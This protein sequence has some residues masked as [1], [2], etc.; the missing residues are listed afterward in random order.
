[1][2][3]AFI[4]GEGICQFGHAVSH[5][6]LTV[7]VTPPPP[8]HEGGAGLNATRLGGEV[9][10]KHW[11]ADYAHYSVFITNPTHF[12]RALVSR[13]HKDVPGA[14]VR[15]TGPWKCLGISIPRLNFL[16]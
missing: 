16:P 6:G 14:K 9:N 3:G 1:M 12:T 2:Y 4:Y 8:R 10:G 13:V 15:A 5:F 11:P 7:S